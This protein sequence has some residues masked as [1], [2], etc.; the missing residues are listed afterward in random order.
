MPYHPHRGSGHAFPCLY[1]SNHQFN[2]FYIYE[3]ILFKFRGGL[4]QLIHSRT[5]GDKRTAWLQCIIDLPDHAPRVTKVD[6]SYI[7]TFEVK[8]LMWCEQMSPNRSH[9]GSRFESTLCSM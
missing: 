5:N 2:T 7:D 8:A 4:F 1:I 6:Y 9:H 3:I